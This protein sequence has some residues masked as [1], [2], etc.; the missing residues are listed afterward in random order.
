[1]QSIDWFSTACY[2][3]RWI[4]RNRKRGRTRR[5]CAR[6]AFFEPLEARVLL[7]ADFGDAPDTGAGTGA[8]NYNTLATDN[9]ASHTRLQ[10][11]AIFGAV[12]RS[13]LCWRN[14]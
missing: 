3:I 6:R 9:G 14:D 5:V 13:P 8:G 4:R 12:Q 2:G 7:A 1:M 11:S 10:P